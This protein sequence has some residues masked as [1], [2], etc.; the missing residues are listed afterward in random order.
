MDFLTHPLRSSSALVPAAAGVNTDSVVPSTLPPQHSPSLPGN[1]SESLEGDAMSFASSTS[2]GRT[3]ETAGVRFANLRTATLGGRDGEEPIEAPSLKNGDWRAYSRVEARVVVWQDRHKSSAAKNAEETILSGTLWITKSNEIIFVVDTSSPPRSEPLTVGKPRKSSFGRRISQSLA[4]SPSA[5][6][7][8]RKGAKSAAPS[9]DA[10]KNS[11]RR[12]WFKR[13]TS[14]VE[15]PVGRREDE[16][17]AEEEGVSGL[18]AFVKNIFS[19]SGTSSVPDDDGGLSLSR[20]RTRDP[21][22]KPSSRPLSRSVSRS[23]SVEPPVATRASPLPTYENHTVTALRVADP[24]FSVTSV[25]FS[26]LRLRSGTASPSSPPLSRSVSREAS[27]TS[28][29]N[30]NFADQV[31]SLPPRVEL[32]IA[33][34]KDEGDEDRADGSGREVTVA[35]CFVEPMLAPLSLL[36]FLQTNQRLQN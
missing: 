34:R 24:A 36:S 26:P 20:T 5:T 22:S 2:D 9:S 23:K 28:S 15:N 25:R 31:D 16:N 4:L 17:D 30:L 8:E 32:D 3:S 1:D 6:W 11:R 33:A 27:G 19:G 10:D 13:S 14:E 21:S 29:Q 7:D 18:L 12:S 35:F